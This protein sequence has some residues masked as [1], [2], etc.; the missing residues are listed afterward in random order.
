MK[1][2]KDKKRSPQIT[3]IEE[4]TPEEIGEI[5][6]VY[7]GPMKLPELTREEAERLYQKLF[8]DKKS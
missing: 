4:M 6:V 3:K 2:I 1:K 7:D 8:V 5:C